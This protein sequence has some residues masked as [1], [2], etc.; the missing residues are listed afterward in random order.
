MPRT[1]RKR[2]TACLWGASLRK[3]WLP[4]V[5]VRTS[6][7]QFLDNFCD[8]G[9]FPFVHAGTFGAGEDERVAA[10]V[11]ADREH[12][13]DAERDRHRGERTLRRPDDGV[14]DHDAEQRKDYGHRQQQQHGVAPVAPLERVEGRRHGVP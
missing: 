14:A 13:G 5:H 1:I 11:G 4:S 6:A 8:F 9:H 2:F 7:G 10:V 3:V 12:G